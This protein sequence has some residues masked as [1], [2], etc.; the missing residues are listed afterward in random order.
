MPPAARWSRAIRVALLTDQAIVRAGVHS[1]LATY[2]ERIDVVDVGGPDRDLRD[3]DVILYDVLGLHEG[4]GKALETAVKA[5]P[6]R[7]LALSRE[8]QPGLTA[9]A[10]A[11]GAI[12][13]IG[14][15]VE[16]EELVA[17]VEAFAAG[18]L[19]DGSQADLDNQADRRR[20]LGRD[21]S[22]S[23]RELDVLGL[24][25]RGRSNDEVAEELY[26]SINTV[27]SLIRSTYRKIGVSSRTQAVAW[28][29]EHG[30]PTTGTIDG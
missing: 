6:G 24:I 28:G 18:H 17:T 29:V 7:V 30:F 5:Q 15:D 25:V 20:Q 21:V 12:A 26:L 23:P 10:L 2:A 27:K 16:G 8:L 1:L 22:L 4:D 11:M 19:E 13:S 14:M 9:R 3:V